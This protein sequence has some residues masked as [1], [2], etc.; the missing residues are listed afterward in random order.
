[1]AQLQPRFGTIDFMNRKQLRKIARDLNIVHDNL[2]SNT[3]LIAAIKA[4]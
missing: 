3:A 1:M 2:T 4:A